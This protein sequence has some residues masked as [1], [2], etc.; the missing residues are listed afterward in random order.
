MLD[1]IRPTL[2][3]PKFLRTR[4]TRMKNDVRLVDL[5]VTPKRI[6][7][8]AGFLGQFQTQRAGNIANAERSNQSEIIIYRVHSQLAN[9]Y[10]VAINAGPPFLESVAPAIHD[11]FPGAG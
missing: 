10:K 3:F 1:Y 8:F 6:R 7:F 5:R 4:G 11:A 2:R 9:L